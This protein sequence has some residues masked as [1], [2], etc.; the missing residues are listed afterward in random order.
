MHRRRFRRRQQ[1]VVSIQIGILRVATRS[2]DPSIRIRVDQ[3]CGMGRRSARPLGETRNEFG[4]RV[5][6][7]G[8]VSMLGRHDENPHG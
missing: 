5:A 7:L 6:G 2:G 3:Y 1:Q 8:L 4:C